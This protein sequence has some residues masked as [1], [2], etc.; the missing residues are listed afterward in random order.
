MCCNRPVTRLLC[1]IVL[2]GA[3]ADSAFAVSAETPDA[4]AAAA[5]KPAHHG[6]N[7]FQNPYAPSFDN[8]RPLAGMR[9]W[10]QL[11]K[12]FPD[13]KNQGYRVPQVQ[14]ERAAIHRPGAAPQF[15]WLGHSTVLVQY[16]GVNLL[17]DPIFSQRCAPVPFLGPQRETQPALQLE[18]LPPIDYVVISHNHYDHLDKPT[19]QA[20]GS[21]PLWLVP[22]G[23]RSWFIKAGIDPTRVQEFDWWQSLHTDD[24]VITATPSQHWSRRGFKDHNKTLWAS[25]HIRV[26]AFSA[27]FG[28]DTGYNPYQ[29]TEIGR[30]LPPADLAMIPIGAYLPRKLMQVSH[31]NPE[32]AV[33]I[34]EDLGARYAIGVHWGTFQLSGEEID[35][36]IADLAQAMRTRDLPPGVFDA[37][38][39]GATRRLP[40]P[41]G[42]RDVSQLHTQPHRIGGEDRSP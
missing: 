20:L 21:G 33:K 16:Q 12:N 27:W 3:A 30:R 17:T 9:M 10:R 37:P 28:G 34:F 15:T 35:A 18:E 40:Y 8:I 26:G 14:A 13:W 4:A 23:L 11:R 39:L 6:E 7:G 5:V 19:V 41:T 38:L 31:V 22:L 42:I 24:A 29:F 32:E 25:W 1:A 36:P 2:S